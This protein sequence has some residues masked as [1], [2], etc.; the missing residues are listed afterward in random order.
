MAVTQLVANGV[1]IGPAGFGAVTGVCGAGP[2]DLPAAWT[3]AG[4]A[5]YN[6]LWS[7]YTTSG[8]DA[9]KIKGILSVIR[10]KGGDDRNRHVPDG[11]VRCG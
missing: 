7:A 11:P 9:F 2:L 8:F 5:T 3:G 6:F 1:T 4:L 10:E